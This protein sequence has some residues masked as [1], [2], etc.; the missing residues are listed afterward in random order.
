[1]ADYTLFFIDR[2]GRVFKRHDHYVP[3]DI[4]A[5]D[6]ARE[7]SGAHQIEVWLGQRF[8][9]RVALDGT[10]S[11]KQDAVTFPYDE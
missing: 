8:V 3:E 11:M 4:E 7:L 5:V 2:D 6:W 10:A 9:T 1:M